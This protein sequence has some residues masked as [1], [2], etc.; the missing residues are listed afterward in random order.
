MHL[1]GL[2]LTMHDSS[3]AAYKDGKFL[4]RKAERQF[5]KKHLYAGLSWAESVLKEWDINN[6]VI[7]KSTWLKGRDPDQLVDGFDLDHH[8]AHVMSSPKKYHVNYVVDAL[9]TGPADNENEQEVYT[10]LLMMGETPRRIKDF[11]IPSVLRPAVWA[12]QFDH[13]EELRKFFISIQ[14]QTISI[15]DW[16]KKL[17]E[18]EQVDEMWPVFVKSIDLPGKTMGLQSY[19]RVDN[20]TVDRWLNSPFPRYTAFCETNVTR[21]DVHMV[22]TLHNFCERVLQKDV[23]P[24]HDFGYSGGVAQNVVINRSLLDAGYKPNVYPWAYDGGCSIGALNYLLD[25]YNIERY[26]DWVQD[27]QTPDTEPSTR[28]IK[29]VAELIANN[30]VVGWYQGNGEVGPRALGNRSILFNP[31]NKHAK[32]IVNRVKQREWWRPF[33]ASVKEDQA[34]RFFDIPVSRHMLINSNGLYSGIPAVTHVDGTCRHQTVPEENSIY[35]NLLDEVEKL[36]DVPMVLNTSLNLR[37]KPI[38]STITEAKQIPLDAICIGDEI[39][40]NMHS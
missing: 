12:Q 24:M 36:I 32:Q 23:P 6:P 4:Y 33:G 39:Y 37:G 20:K 17:I 13:E 35:Y 3:V 10:G 19:G 31:T 29:K 9:S 18:T 7:A 27:D 8:Y 30:K 11:P 15:T 16:A 34:H 28:T 25:K 1:V 21:P 5:S 26:S 40:E 14:N 38:C 2:G 22:A